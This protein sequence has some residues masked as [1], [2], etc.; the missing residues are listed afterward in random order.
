MKWNI[1]Q[2]KNRQPLRWGISITIIL[3]IL[4]HSIYTLHR[5]RTIMAAVHE[6]IQPLTWL[7]GHWD[8]FEA[9]GEFPTIGPFTYRETLDVSHV[10]QPMLN[11]LWVKLGGV[12]EEVALVWRESKGRGSCNR[13]TTEDHVGNQG[14][15][16]LRHS[17]HRSRKYGAPC[18]TVATSIP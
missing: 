10:G 8:S 18:V 6:A 11:F 2:E 17:G 13:L 15:G 16:L 12:G 7:L 5:F 3:T 4:I 14:C 9:N 1:L